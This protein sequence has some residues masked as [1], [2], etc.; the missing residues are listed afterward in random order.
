MKIYIVECDDYDGHDSVGYFT[1]SKKAESCC[2]YLNKTRHS[3]YENFHWH[4]SE[5]NLNQTDYESLNK[6][7]D[8]QENLNLKN[9]LERMRQEA[10]VEIERLKAIYGL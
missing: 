7:F 5:Y 3:E 9:K 6:E 8:E 10:L 4:L 1:D 2:K